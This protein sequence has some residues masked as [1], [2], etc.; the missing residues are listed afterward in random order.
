MLAEFLY[1]EIGKFKQEQKKVLTVCKAEMR[2]LAYKFKTLYV[3]ISY[4]LNG[5]LST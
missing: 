4:F 5:I 1:F 3:T 2:G